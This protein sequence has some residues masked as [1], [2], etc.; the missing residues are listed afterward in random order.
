MK[1]SSPKSKKG[2]PKYYTPKSPPKYKKVSS[3]KEI[4]EH[5]I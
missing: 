5:G 4:H 2:I 1:K 3:E